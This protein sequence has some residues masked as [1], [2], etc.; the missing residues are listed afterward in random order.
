MNLEMSM[1]HIA[2]FHSDFCARE[3]IKKFLEFLGGGQCKP[4][5]YAELHG[6]AVWSVFMYF[7]KI[8]RGA[9]KIQKGA[10]APLKW[11]SAHAVTIK[12]DIAGEV[13]TVEH[14]LRCGGVIYCN[15]LSKYDN[16]IL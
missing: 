11:N 9:L 6:S 2:V 3:L 5:C 8:L 12:H 15:I 4:R 10:L 7:F 16:F 1:I 14:I 13:T